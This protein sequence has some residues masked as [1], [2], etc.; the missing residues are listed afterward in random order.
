MVIEDGARGRAPSGYRHRSTRCDAAP[1]S[2]RKTRRRAPSRG[3]SWRPRRSAGGAPIRL[4]RRVPAR[5]NGVGL[6]I[7][8]G[9]RT[10]TA[11]TSPTPGAPPCS[12]TAAIG[13]RSKPPTYAATGADST[14]PSRSPTSSDPEATSRS[15]RGQGSRTD[16]HALTYQ[17]REVPQSTMKDMSVTRL[18]IRR[19]GAR[20]ARRCRS[21]RFRRRGSPSGR[22]VLGRRPP[23][24]AR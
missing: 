18:A 22:G 12:E 3:W 17:R 6:L 8:P 1:L 23:L 24:P 2:S 20:T 4:H 19:V 11:S 9:N 16:T 7:A 15:H 5:P 10:S 21:R 13:S 14:S